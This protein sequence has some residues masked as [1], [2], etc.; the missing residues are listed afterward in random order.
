[1]RI[2]RADPGAPPHGRS[3]RRI[4]CAVVAALAHRR[5]APRGL[6]D[7]RD[8]GRSPA[9]RASPHVL[10]RAPG[11]ARVPGDRAA[12]NRRFVGRMADAVRPLRHY[13]LR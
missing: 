2:R 7:D 1:M 4:A 11:P 13:G 8:R 6:P 10:W 12:G 9:S 5:W 3:A